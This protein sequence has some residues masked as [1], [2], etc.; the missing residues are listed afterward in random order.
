[1][2]WYVFDCITE[3]QVTKRESSFIADATSADQER[4]YLQ[5]SAR[6]WEPIDNQNYNYMEQI[7]SRDKYGPTRDFL[8]EH[9]VLINLHFS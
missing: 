7:T 3:L 8:K 2:Y 6:Y 5:D 1:M 9:K 4:S